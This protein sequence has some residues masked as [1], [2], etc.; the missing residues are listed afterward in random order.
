MKNLYTICNLD[1]RAH[2]SNYENLTDILTKEIEQFNESCQK[3]MNRDLKLKLI[4]KFKNIIAD[5]LDNNSSIEVFGSFANS[6]CLPWSDI[7]LVIQ[8]PPNDS[9]LL[10]FIK[11]RLEKEQNMI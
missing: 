7:D 3:A 5:L 4:D 2:D 8:D 11:E 6:L 10:S 9:E 1:F